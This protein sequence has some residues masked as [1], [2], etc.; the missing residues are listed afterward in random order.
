[1]KFKILL[2]SIIGIILFQVSFVQAQVGVE[3]PAASDDASE[4][5]PNPPSVVDVVYRAKIV[6]IIEEGQQTDESGVSQP[7][8]KL[9]VKILNGNEKGKHVVVDNG[10][11]FVIGEFQKFKKGDVVV[12]ER[13][14]VRVLWLTISLYTLLES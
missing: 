10:V 3:N 4:I 8:Q 9:E 2:A 5:L 6:G 7:Y 14:W 13:G 1:M 11:S 12:L